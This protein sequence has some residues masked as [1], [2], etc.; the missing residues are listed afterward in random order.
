MNHSKILVAS[1]IIFTLSACNGGL[2][3][4]SAPPSNTA[5]QTNPSVWQQQDHPIATAVH[6]ILRERQSSESAGLSVL[7]VQ[8]GEILYHAS[9]GL[10]NRNRGARLND[11]T[12][13]RIASVSKTFTAIAVMQLVEDGV[14]GLNDSI[15]DYLPEL[16][17]SWQAISID[18]LLS[19]RAG[20]YDVLNDGRFN[21]SGGY[22]NSS[23]VNYFSGNP[24]LEF[25]PG[26]RMDYS[27]SGYILLAEVVARASRRSFDDYMRANIFQPAQM[28]D[29]YLVGNY[30]GLRSGDALNNATSSEINGQNYQ[31]TGAMG[32]VSSTNDF[33]GFF[34]AMRDGRLISE[35]SLALMREPRGRAF[36]RDYG[37]GLMLGENSYGHGGLLGGY[38]SDM[39]IDAGLDLQVVVLGNGGPSSSS[40]IGAIRTAVYDNAE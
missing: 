22:T 32:Q 26:S 10:A 25:E 33:I 23:L 20:V 7:I 9:K 5:P 27:N 11:S 2:D 21:L 13:F 3:T 31:F 40:L 17:S 4:G 38:R 34:E 6:Q 30:S 24:V 29:S 36:G 35:D 12:G 18:Y 39:F 14:I 28:W 1:I 16:D 37:F 19:H 15:L 8:N